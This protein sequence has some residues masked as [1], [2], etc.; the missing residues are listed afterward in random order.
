MEMGVGVAGEGGVDSSQFMK[1]AW[2]KN[3]DLI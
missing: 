2:L 3:L 1:F